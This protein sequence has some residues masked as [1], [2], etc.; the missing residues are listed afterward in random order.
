MRFA[1][2]NVKLALAN[3]VDHFVLEPSAKTLIPMKFANAMSS[4]KPQ[5]GMFLKVK[6][7]I[8]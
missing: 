3:L 4:L 2:A 6:P 1:L 7:R 5:G 8:Q